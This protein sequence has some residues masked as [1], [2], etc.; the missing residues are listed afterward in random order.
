MLLKL[1]SAKTR[2]M[3]P[4]IASIME[5]IIKVKGYTD[6]ENFLFYR[7]KKSPLLIQAHIDTVSPDTRYDNYKL[8]RTLGNLYSANGI[9]GADD[10]AGVYALCSLASICKENNLVMPSILFTNY[11][12]TGGK[13]MDVFMKKI[14]LKHL[15]HIHF[16]TAI[17]RRGCND[18]VT[19]I[20]IDDKVEEY[21]ENFGFISAI[22]S[23]SDIKEFTKLTKIPSVNLSCGYYSQHTANEVLHFDELQMTISRVVD[24]IKNPI[25]KLYPC[26][27][28]EERW[29]KVWTPNKNK[30][31]IG[32]DTESEKQRV[33]RNID[34]INRNK[35][36][37][38][39]DCELC[40][41]SNNKVT[42]V[43]DLDTREYN[44]LCAT[45]ADLIEKN[46]KDD[47]YLKGYGW[48]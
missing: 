17:D 34:K 20:N 35:D 44:F 43:F 11:E 45:C 40:G 31:Y 16:A 39:R 19:Y 8:Y 12:E 13:G 4:L 24:I 6:G 18:Y 36:G 25:D 9:L 38:K 28:E 30:K 42:L 23:Y 29:K 37:L 2:D 33:S 22:G 1:F 10:R 46:N 27:G 15:D 7:N 3:L 41:C 47:G 21:I 26:E 32:Y 5:E 14:D 48:Y